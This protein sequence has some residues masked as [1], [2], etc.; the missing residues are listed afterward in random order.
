MRDSL[1]CG[2][3]NECL[4]HV[5]RPAHL[6]LL[7]CLLSCTPPTWVPAPVTAVQRRLLGCYEVHFA[8]SGSSSWRFRTD[9]LADRLAINDRRVRFIQPDARRQPLAYWRAPAADSIVLWTVMGR[10]GQ[11][12]DIRAA[13]VGD[14]LHGIAVQNNGR[15]FGVP[16]DSFHVSGLR[17]SCPQP[18]R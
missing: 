6:L 15:T 1:G 10:E 3:S 9:S 12:I 4:V 16:D 8:G 14:S 18:V 17:I 2:Q 11:G 13:V 7:S 5:P